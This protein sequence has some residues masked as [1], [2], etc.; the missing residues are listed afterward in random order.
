MDLVFSDSFILLSSGPSLPFDFCWPL[1]PLCRL[2]LL[3]LPALPPGT[4]ECLRVVSKLLVHCSAQT[5]TGRSHRVA[6]GAVAETKISFLSSAWGWGVAQ[7]HGAVVTKHKT[8]RNPC[9]YIQLD[10]P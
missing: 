9:C 1:G 3:C 10:L 4:S 6:W 2:P 8:G 5:Q 7:W